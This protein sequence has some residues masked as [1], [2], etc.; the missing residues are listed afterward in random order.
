MIKPT[1]AIGHRPTHTYLRRQKN[2]WNSKQLPALTSLL[3]TL[4][5]DFKC[6][7]TFIAIVLRTVA[8]HTH[9]HAALLGFAQ[10]P[11]AHYTS[12]PV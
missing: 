4:R 3:L 9:T 2:L 10:K 5:E 11:S 7:G 8:T 6:R 12:M 1:Q